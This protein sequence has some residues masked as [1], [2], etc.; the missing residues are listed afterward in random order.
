MKHQKVGG[1]T[2]VRDKKVGGITKI[3]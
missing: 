1:I 3:K 2:L